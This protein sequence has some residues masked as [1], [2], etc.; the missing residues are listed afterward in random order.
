MSSILSNWEEAKTQC[1]QQGEGFRLATWETMDEYMAVKDAI[2]SDHGTDL[3]V[4]AKWANGLMAYQWVYDG[5]G[6]EDAMWL[7]GAAPPGA[8][9]N[10]VY[11][12]SDSSAL[13]ISP[14]NDQRGFICEF[15]N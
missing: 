8:T 6:I 11:F 13:W 4:A 10:C 15:V 2:N 1:E 7:N 12:K 9:G 14:P 3:W 5:L